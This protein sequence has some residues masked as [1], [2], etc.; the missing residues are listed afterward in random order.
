MKKVGLTLFCLVFLFT[1]IAPAP[2]QAAPAIT[3]MQ[4]ESG[5]Y[6]GNVHCLAIHPEIP[7]TLYAGTDGGVYKSLDGG[8]TWAATNNGLTNYQVLSVAILPGSPETVFAGAY[9]EL[10][11]TINGGES[12]D[13]VNI[14]LGFKLFYS[15]G[16][17]TRSNPV[18]IYASTSIGILFQQ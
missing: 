16:F 9:G 18:A 13:V 8:D 1:A 4:P 10:F 15:V 5:I 6:G 2:A 7:G 11:K 3:W 17:D 14:G 12:W